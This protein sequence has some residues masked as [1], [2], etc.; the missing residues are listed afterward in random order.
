MTERA[1]ARSCPSR[2]WS[3]TRTA[4]SAWSD[5][6]P[7]SIGRMHGFHGNFGV[8]V[9]AYAYV[10]AARRATGCKE[11]SERAVAERELPAA[12]VRDAFPL[13]YPDGRPMHEF[14]ATARALRERD[15]HPG[16]G[17][18]QAPDRPRLPPLDGVLPA[19]GGGGA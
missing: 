13:A 7:D 10:F 8:L 2:A 18:R 6:G 11:V 15:G 14:V 12:L 17:R 1:R 19:R 3:A 9:R 4:R 5:D 16:D